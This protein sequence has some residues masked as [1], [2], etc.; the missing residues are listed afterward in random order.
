[1]PPRCPHCSFYLHRLEWEEDTRGWQNGADEFPIGQGNRDYWD[2]ENTDTED[3]QYKCEHCNA[4]L[5][6]DEVSELEAQFFRWEEDHQD[7]NLRNAVVAA[8]AAI[9]S[10]QPVDNETYIV[11]NGMGIGRRPGWMNP[12]PTE[13]VPE[14][15]TILEN[16][17]N[18]IMRGQDHRR[19]KK[20]HDEQKIQSCPEC[21]YD[22]YD[23]NCNEMVCP[24]CSAVYELNEER[25]I[26]TSPRGRSFQAHIVSEVVTTQQRTF[27][28]A[29]M[30]NRWLMWG[31]QAG[32]SQAF[33]QIV[34]MIRDES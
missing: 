9:S 3:T 20:L 10:G 22:Y 14:E 25:R 32:R 4:N 27:I 8:N 11:M 24:K 23:E 16:E 13:I 19:Y 2:S 34:R 33:Q 26:R 28:E 31:R 5:S 12:E 1:M 7:G 15:E 17:T 18:V 21:H 29:I 6:D 30:N